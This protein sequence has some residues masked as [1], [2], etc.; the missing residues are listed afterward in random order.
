MADS[1]LPPLATGSRDETLA[2]PGG[3]GGSPGGLPRRREGDG[4]ARCST[5]ASEMVGI[6]E[7]SVRM[8]ICATAVEEL[9]WGLQGP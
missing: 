5:G 4:A 6:D 3:D 7:L 9:D 1:H 2:Q 8:K